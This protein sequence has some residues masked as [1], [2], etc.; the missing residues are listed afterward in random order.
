MGVDGLSGTRLY[1][2]EIKKHLLYVI[3]L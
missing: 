2:K 1:I 3:N